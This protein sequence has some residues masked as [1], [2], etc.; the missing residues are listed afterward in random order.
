[1]QL[2]EFWAPGK[3]RPIRTVRLRCDVCEV[4]FERNAVPASRQRVHHFCGRVC[5]SRWQSQSV[6]FSQ[7]VVAAN[8]E[9]RSDPIRRQQHAER[10]SQ[11]MRQL[12]AT[13]PEIREKQRTARKKRWE[14]PTYREARSGSN[15]HLT[16]KIISW[17]QPWMARDVVGRAWVVEVK[18]LFGQHC[19]MCGASRRLHA[20]HIIPKSLAPELVYDLNNGVALCHHCHDGKDNPQNVHRLLREDP[21]RYQELMRGLLLKRI[22]GHVVRS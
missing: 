16:G 7:A 11:R 10:N 13:R 15:H 12:Y 3:R 9:R 5:S 18:R 20:H 1:M 22:H 19:A 17:W 4:V 6:E 2:E 14:D 21:D 8:A